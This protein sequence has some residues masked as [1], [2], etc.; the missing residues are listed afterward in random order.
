MSYSR[1]QLENWIKSIRVKGRVLDVG[2]SQLPIEKR[3]R[4]E[5]GTIFDILD[6]T[7]PHECKER[8]KIE[9]DIQ[10]EVKEE[11]FDLW[12]DS[13]GVYDSAFCIEVSEYWWDPVEALKNIRHFLKKGGDL[14]ISFH[15]YYPV[16]NPSSEDCL[17]YTP[18]GARKI[19]EKCGFEIID[20]VPRLLRDK[21][22]LCKLGEFWGGE[23]MRPSKTYS[24]HRY[25]GMLI[26]ARKK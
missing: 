16:H 3:V 9:L 5:E 25:Q 4:H 18:E 15:H 10:E 2:G 20:E 13:D 12:M 6:F 14:Y 19:L 11:N 7:Q 1:E 22:S 24:E 23:G 26:K 21:E 17:R 8:P